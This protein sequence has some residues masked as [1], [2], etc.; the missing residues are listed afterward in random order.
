MGI[1]ILAVLGV[2]LLLK[3]AR[4]VF[5]PFVLAGLLFYALDPI[6][7]WMQSIRIPRALGAAVVMVVVVALVK[8]R[9]RIRRGFPL[10]RP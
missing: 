5:I 8:R 4:E 10:D 1:S 7:D 6:V 3:E 9:R 2:I